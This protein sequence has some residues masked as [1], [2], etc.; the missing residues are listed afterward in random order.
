MAA[1]SEPRAV[2][3]DD[4][5]RAGGSDAGIR[6]YYIRAYR[7]HHFIDD[8]H[9]VAPHLQP[10]GI[11]ANGPRSSTYS[12]V[13]AA[14]DAKAIDAVRLTGGRRPI[15]KNATGRPLTQIR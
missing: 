4:C 15:S 9:F 5:G 12:L 8:L 1:E 11:E 10:L 14:A 6:R 2:A 7:L 13:A 3:G